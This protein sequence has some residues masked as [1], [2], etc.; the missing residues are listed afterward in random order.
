MFDKF[1]RKFLRK[2]GK[3]SDKPKEKYAEAPWSRKNHVLTQILRIILWGLVSCG[4]VSLVLMLTLVPRL[5]NSTPPPVIQSEQPAGQEAAGELAQQAVIVMLT[6]T[7]KDEEKAK[8]LLPGFTLPTKPA[9]ISNVRLADARYNEK[10]KSWSITVAVD[11]ESIRRYYQV[12]VGRDSNSGK[13]QLLMLPSMIAAPGNAPAAASPYSVQVPVDKGPASAATDFLN[14]YLAGSGDVS[15]YA[16]PEVTIEPVRPSPFKGVE[17]EWAKTNKDLPETPVD[18]DIVELHVRAKGVTPDDQKQ[19][20]EY[21][22]E[23]KLRASR[24]ELNAIQSALAPVET[25]EPK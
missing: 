2:P 25:N 18:G 23:M 3:Q 8:E 16:S 7:Q 9:E 6:S 24:W 15:R 14:A 22:M 10:S 11:V 1:L 20:L 19:Q 5:A 17:L 21:V 12:I 4:V 13:L